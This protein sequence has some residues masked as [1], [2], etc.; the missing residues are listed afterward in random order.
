MTERMTITQDGEVVGDTP[1]DW[2]LPFARSLLDELLTP[3]ERRTVSPPCT[4]EIAE[5]LRQA[6][7]SSLNCR[8]V[9]LPSPPVSPDDREFVGAWY[10]A[11][12][13]FLFAMGMNGDA[14]GHLH[15]AARVLPDDPRLLFDRGSYAET[16]GLPI[17][18][19]V[20]EWASSRPNTVITGIPAEQKTNAEAEQHYR[21]ALEVD[22]S[23]VEA[24]VRLA[25]LLDRRGRHDE[26][27]AQIDKALEAQPAGVV[28]FYARIIAGRIAVARG[29]YDEALRHYQ[30]ASSIHPYAQSALLGASHASLMLADVPQTL[31]PLGQLG[32]DHA[33]VA[34]PWWDYQLGAGRD[35]NALLAALW[36]RRAK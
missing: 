1:G 12:A 19:A 35:V 14:T 6:R 2:N 30:A 15:Y 21:R 11:V 5:G 28:G 22:P 4:E 16:F 29:R 24:R 36:A 26:A 10:H 32:G 9:V 17:Y 33:K 25:R 27:A 34:D 23:Y 20:H 31:A 3:T 13:A 18:Q 8:M 7:L